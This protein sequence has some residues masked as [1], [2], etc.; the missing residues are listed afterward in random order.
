MCSSGLFGEPA[1]DGRDVS[2]CSE[3]WFAKAGETFEMSH[4]FDEV[5]L[6]VAS[7]DQRSVDLTDLRCKLQRHA[8][9]VTCAKNEIEVFCHLLAGKGRA[10]VAGPKWCGLVLHHW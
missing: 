10:E 4:R 7:R 5:A 1:A 3:P 9:G 8:D 2:R 6:A